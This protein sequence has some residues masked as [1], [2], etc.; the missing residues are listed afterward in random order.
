MKKS[1]SSN[2]GSDAA[3]PSSSTSPDQKMGIEGADVDGKK[4]EEGNDQSP[5][6]SPDSEGDAKV[7][8]AEDEAI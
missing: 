5:P 6:S 3:V 8:T 1:T 4:I 7:F 2:D